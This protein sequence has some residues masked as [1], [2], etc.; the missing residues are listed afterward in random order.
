[1]ICSWLYNYVVSYILGTVQSYISLRKQKICE[2]KLCLAW[3]I[4]NHCRNS[5]L[6]A[7]LWEGHY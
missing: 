4:R 5:E 1:M 2:D 7:E 6:H 3:Y